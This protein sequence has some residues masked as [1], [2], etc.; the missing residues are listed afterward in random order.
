MTLILF[1]VRNPLKNHETSLG[2]PLLSSWEVTKAPVVAAKLV[3]GGAFLG[4]IPLKREQAKQLFILST[5]N[6]GL[7]WFKHVQPQR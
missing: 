7:T 4:Q 1:L 2:D 3:L 5:K 6:V